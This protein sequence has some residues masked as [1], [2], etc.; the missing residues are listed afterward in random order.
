MYDNNYTQ[1]QE[2][3]NTGSKALVVRAEVALVQFV[4]HV[5]PVGSAEVG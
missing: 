2:E 1:K 4:R 5:V 3:E